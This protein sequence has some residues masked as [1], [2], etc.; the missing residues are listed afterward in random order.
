[1]VTTIGTRACPVLR[2][3]AL[4]TTLVVIQGKVSAI[5]ARKGPPISLISWLAPT[6]FKKGLA[7]MEMGKAKASD[8]SPEKSVE[9]LVMCDIAVASPRPLALETRMAAPAPS[10]LRHRMPINIR[11]LDSP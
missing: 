10:V 9:T 7:H 3:T 8:K 1:M 5:K 4:A 11:L 6:A 2:K